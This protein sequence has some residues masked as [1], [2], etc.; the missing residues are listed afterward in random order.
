MEVSWVSIAAIAI[1]LIALVVAAFSTGFLRPLALG[2][3]FATCLVALAT[4]SL[5]RGTVKVREI[6]VEN[7]S[8]WTDL[9]EPAAELDRLTPGDF[10]RAVRVVT[11]D[12]DSIASNSELLDSRTSM[13]V[14]R[15]DFEGIVREGVNVCAENLARDLKR[16]VEIVS[17]GVPSVDR[18]QKILPTIESLASQADRIANKLY[19]FE[20]G[21]SEVV[22]VQVEP[23]RRGAEKLSRDLR[24]LHT[25]IEKYA[26]TSAGPIG[27]TTQPTAQ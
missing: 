18:V 23:L 9:G 2:T 6:P 8:A 15:P 13:L 22:R 11:T 17:S 12:L 16:V 14:G 19:E 1:A 4:L 24:H 25:H 21:K 27:P 3:A 26:K 5:R 10:F 20:K 7:F